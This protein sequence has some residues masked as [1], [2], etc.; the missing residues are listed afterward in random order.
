MRINAPSSE[1]AL[2]GADLEVVLQSERLESLVLPKC[3]SVEDVTFVAEHVAQAT[4]ISYVIRTLTRSRPPLSLVLS[5]ESAP[6]LLRLPQLLRDAQA[7]LADEFRGVAQIAAVLFASEDYCASSGVRRTR[8]RKGL[9]YPRANMAT[10]AKAMGIQA[11][12]RRADRLTQDMVCID[13]KDPAYLQE[14]CAEGA[15]LGF[16]G[17]QAIHP[18]QLDIIA[19]AFS[20]TEA[21]TCKTLAH[22]EIA[23]AKA[24]VTAYESASRTQHKG[25]VGLEHG[26]RTIMIDAPMLLQAQRTLARARGGY[27]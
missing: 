5:V 11:I 2:A 4:H 15:E 21:G 24:I 14:E 25:A 27:T 26:G 16:D 19:R 6:G 12:V 8:E 17:K 13:Y 1:R 20:P 18:A 9:L 22:S 7:R 23:E 3:E 10:I